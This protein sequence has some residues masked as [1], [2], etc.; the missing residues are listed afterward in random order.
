[1]VQNIGSV[2]PVL[3][4]PNFTAVLSVELVVVITLFNRMT[5]FSS[6]AS[7]GVILDN[8]MMQ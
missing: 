7:G 8:R 1:M 4:C 6:Y 3:F 2:H 5:V